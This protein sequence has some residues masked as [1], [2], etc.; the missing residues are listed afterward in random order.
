V[1]PPDAELGQLVV[2]WLL[3]KKPAVRD[4]EDVRG[5]FERAARLARD[6]AF[7][8][9]AELDRLR[10]SA[11]RV[12]GAGEHDLFEDPLARLREGAGNAIRSAL[13]WE[14]VGGFTGPA[15]VDLA[16]RFR[17]DEADW[18]L[19]IASSGYDGVAIRQVALRLRRVAREVSRV[20][21]DR[22][23]AA[24]RSGLP[25]L[26]G[27][28][29]ARGIS[30]ARLVRYLAANLAESKKM[31]DPESTWRERVKVATRPR[32]GTFGKAKRRSS[33]R[34]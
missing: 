21:T 19:E 16:R 29:R 3:R 2:H 26:I 31:Q 34:K 5:R 25:E 32:V 15:L 33:P 4:L 10:E 6:L 7:E 28:A 13:R 12:Y 1:G 14:N 30:R 18:T 11:P 20:L 27:E 17:D 9:E 23:A 8:M 22:R 24:S